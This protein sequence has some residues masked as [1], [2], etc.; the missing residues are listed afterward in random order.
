MN[1]PHLTITKYKAPN[2]QELFKDPELANK[3]HELNMVLNT[4]P[5]AT[6]VKTHPFIKN[7]QYLP[8]DKVEHLL[9]FLFKKYRIEILREGTSF[10]GVYVVVRVH[11]LNPLSGEL[12]FH[13]GIGA[14]QIQVKSGS[15]PSDLSN[16]N[17]GALSMAYPLAKTLAIKDAC[18]H[19]GKLF[20]S[21]LN[22][23]ETLSF[24][25]DEKIR[26]AAEDRLLKLID[27]CK[28]HDELEKLRE[29]LT[30]STQINFD[31]KWNS[32]K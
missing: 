16:I 30:D 11:Y 31:E 9:K 7:Y 25:E 10:N 19:F 3:N 21:D 20:G 32:L 6:W 4:P 1:T 24:G 2:I 26:S 5:P 14:S 23:K 15:S 22:R 28:N 8:I 18:D 27:N 12:D 29:H 17:N 13:D